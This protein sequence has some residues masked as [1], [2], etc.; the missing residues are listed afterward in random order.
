MMQWSR[1]PIYTAGFGLVGS[2][3]SLIFIAGH[4]GHRTHHA[5]DSALLIHHFR[6][7]SAGNYPDLMS[8]RKYED[9]L[10]RRVVNHFIRCCSALK[11]EKAVCDTCCMTPTCG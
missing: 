4:P 11:T 5:V 7:V 10:Y 6:S 8:A 1:L 9:F 3:A 2:M